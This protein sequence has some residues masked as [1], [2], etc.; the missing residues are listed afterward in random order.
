[1]TH[2]LHRQGSLP[3]LREDFVVFSMACQS[4]N[5]KG[6][7]PKIC[8]VFEII[9]KYQPV[10]FGDVKTGNCFKA[11][12]EA[13]ESNFQENSYIHFVFTSKET[14]GKALRD[15]KKADIG[16]SVVVS[17]VVNDIDQLCRQAGLKVHTVEFSGGIYGRTDRLTEGPV[18]EITTMCGHGLIAANLVRHLVKQVRKGK[19]KAEE[20]ACELARQCQCGVFNPQRA[21][22]LIEQLSKREAI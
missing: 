3:D 6:S 17:G 2:T 1:M 9:E 11:T 21:R 20:A 7:V 5:A 18:L 22:H 13:M 19:K 16:L 15:L 10:N 4:V 14:V 8:K 12:K